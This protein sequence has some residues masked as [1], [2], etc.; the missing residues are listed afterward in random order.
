MDH[1]T[2]RTLP[3]EKAQGLARRLKERAPRLE[4]RV[5]GNRDFGLIEDPNANVRTILERRPLSSYPLYRY[6]RNGEEPIFQNLITLV[7]TNCGHLEQFA[8]AVLDGATPE[9]YGSEAD[10]G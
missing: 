9:Q 2:I 1:L 4:C 7:C 5:C 3:D 10:H 6:S 8:E